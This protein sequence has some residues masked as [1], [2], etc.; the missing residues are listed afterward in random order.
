M[1]RCLLALSLSAIGCLDSASAQIIVPTDN[2]VAVSGNVTRGSAAAQLN[3]WTRATGGS[4]PGSPYFWGRNHWT[5]WSASNPEKGAC[6]TIGAWYFSQTVTAIPLRFTEARSGVSIVLNVQAYAEWSWTNIY[7]TSHWRHIGDI[8]TATCS[9]VPNDG[10]ML[11]AYVPSS[12]LAR[13]PIGGVWKANLHLRL[14]EGG[15]GP[16]A[17]FTA[18]ITANVTDDQ[19]MQVFLP[20][21]GSATPRVDL[22]LRSLPSVGGARTSGERTLDACLY[23]GFNTN[24]QRYTVRM[25]DPSSTGADEAGRFFVRHPAPQGAAGQNRIEYEVRSMT[26]PFGS[27]QYQSGQDRVFANIPD[28]ERRQVFLANIPVPVICTP[29]PLT[30][31]TPEFTSAD[32]RAGHYSGVL[33]IEFSA[34]T[35]AP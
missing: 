11:T 34:S 23:D 15:G 31:R 21:F 16:I 12:E 1:R 22:N 2:H 19:N 18:A 24:S 14:N 27:T 33:R 4:D 26:L 28:A 30:L 32:K 10:K 6:P 29:W 25:T 3:I 5:C 20:E 35:T 7:C 13:L 9:G 8:A 17:E